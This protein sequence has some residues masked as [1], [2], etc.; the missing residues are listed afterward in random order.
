MKHGAESC[1]RAM[2]LIRAFVRCIF[3]GVMDPFY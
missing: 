3:L 1:R 2:E